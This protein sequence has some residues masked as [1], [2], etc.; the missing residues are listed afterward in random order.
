MS[1]VKLVI[2]RCS[3]HW[4]N[5]SLRLHESAA[6]QRV[7]TRL[8]QKPHQLHHYNWHIMILPFQSMTEMYSW[9]ENPSNMWHI[10]TYMAVC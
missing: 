8:Q 2:R 7:T 10:C 1:T 5:R 6:A 4:C 3:W 9:T